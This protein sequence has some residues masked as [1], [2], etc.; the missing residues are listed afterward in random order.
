[1]T[2]MAFDAAHGAFEGVRSLALQAMQT[3]A[4]REEIDEALHGACL[5]CGLGSAYIASF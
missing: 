5:F 3:G 1:M 2:G 4:T